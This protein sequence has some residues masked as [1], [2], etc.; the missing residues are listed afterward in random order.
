MKSILYFIPLVLSACGVT[1]PNHFT[2]KGKIGQLNAPAKIYFDYTS[3]QGS[4]SDSALLADGDFAF[5]GDIDCPTLSRIILDYDGKGMQNAARQGYSYL[6]YIDRGKNVV[7]SVDSLHRLKME[8][9]PINDKYKTYND[10]VGG[11]PQ[12][13]SA[14]IG[15]KVSRFTP[16]QL[17]DTALMKRVN[18]EFHGLLAA[19]QQ[20]QMQYVRRFPE[21]FFSL[22]AL[23]ENQVRESNLTQLDS[24]FR[25]LSSE[26]QEC[27]M[28]RAF[29]ARL[30][31]VRATAVGNIAPDFTQNDTCN[32][33]VSLSD[34][35][36][37]YL[38]LDFWAS[39]C[40]PC[41]AENPYMTRAY[42]IYKNRNFEI[43]GVSLDGQTSRA[44]WQEAIRKDGVTWPQV[45]D[46]KAWDNQAALLYGIRAIPQN[47]LLDPQGRIIAKDLRGENLLIKLAEMLPETGE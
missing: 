42:D 41:R 44:A 21:S 38:L 20:K 47:Y 23:S 1:P 11:A 26:L 31:A 37:K 39:W 22:A 24:L 25:S 27:S 16:A 9:S 15:E 32:R 18:E 2:L 35:R 34:F 17:Q 46:L 43:L 14:R 12:D 30:T 6:L 40:G 33:P 19:R 36:G 3:E 45:S 5:E 29:E 7:S 4:R 8:H 13:I 10:Y 28:G